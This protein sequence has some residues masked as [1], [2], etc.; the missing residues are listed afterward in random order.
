[1]PESDPSACGFTRAVERRDGQNDTK[2]Q[3]TRL[4]GEEKKKKKKKR[5]GGGE[6]EREKQTERQTD[7]N[8]QID[9]L[10][11]RQTGRLLTI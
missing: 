1:M 7:K 2:W 10:R 6:R 4:K 5:R 3:K 11:E 9:G 8:K